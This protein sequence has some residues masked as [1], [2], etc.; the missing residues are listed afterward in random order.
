MIKYY[1]LSNTALKP[2]D[3]QTS[4]LIVNYDQN[5]SAYAFTCF[6]VTYDV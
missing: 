5:L 3:G 4:T 1:L 2:S 6:F